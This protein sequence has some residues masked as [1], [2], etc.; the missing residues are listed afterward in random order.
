MKN[1][2]GEGE[3]TMRSFEW[4]A[5]LLKDSIHVNNRWMILFEKLIM[6][7]FIFAVC[8]TWGVWRSQETN[9]NGRKSGCPSKL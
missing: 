7:E 4:E 1:V 9:G 6:I 2:E 8:R 5:I 3:K